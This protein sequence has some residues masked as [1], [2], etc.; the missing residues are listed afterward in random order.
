MFL[1]ADPS[2]M[3]KLGGIHAAQQDEGKALRMFLVS[4][5]MWGCV[6]VHMPMRGEGE[7]TVRVY[8]TTTSVTARQYTLYK[9]NTNTIIIIIPSLCFPRTP[10]TCHECVATVI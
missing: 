4:G 3:V 7:S 1:G 9:P 6:D 2:L 10:T 8:G 5:W